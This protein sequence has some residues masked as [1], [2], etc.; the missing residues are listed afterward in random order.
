VSLPPR[1]A[2]AAPASTP[3]SVSTRT[4]ARV[5]G[6]VA[7]LLGLVETG[8]GV[9][10]W[11]DI[12]HYTGESST[13]AIGYLFALVV[14]VPGAL[15]LALGLLGWVLAARIVG[16]IASVLALMAVLSPLLLF[17]SFWLG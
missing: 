5:T 17:A 1:P 4:F 9:I 3:A 12:A 13:A 7:A 8:L 16:P 10:V 6:V 15:G 14:G 11:V 2:P